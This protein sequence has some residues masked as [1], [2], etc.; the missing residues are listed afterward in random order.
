MVDHVVQMF[1]G[2][3]DGG[4]SF[5]PQETSVEAYLYHTSLAGNGFQLF[6]GQVARVVAQGF[7]GGVGADYRC[8]A[9]SE[10]IVETLFS[11]VGE[12][13]HHSYPVHLPD[14]LGSEFTDSFTGVVVAG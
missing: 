9:D 4:R 3:A 6:I 12:V 1:D 14:D 10:G 5:F 7:A 2:I 13:Y 8:L 11:G